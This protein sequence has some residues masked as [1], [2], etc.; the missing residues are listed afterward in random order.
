METTMKATS[1]ILQRIVQ[2][3]PPKN[4]RL[5]EAVLTMLASRAHKKMATNPPLPAVCMLS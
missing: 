1:Y 5:L 4:T 2:E 3:L